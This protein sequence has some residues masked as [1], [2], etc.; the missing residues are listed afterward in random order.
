MHG[1]IFLIIDQHLAA[2]TE[3]IQQTTK[4][5]RD[6][7]VFSKIL[8]VQN[9]VIRSKLERYFWR[10]QKNIGLTAL[11]RSVKLRSRKVILQVQHD[12]G[13]PLAPSTA[14][15]VHSV[16]S[17]SSESERSTTSPGNSKSVK[18]EST[19]DSLKVNITKFKY[20]YSTAEEICSQF[21]KER[22]QKVETSQ[23]GS[24]PT[25]YKKKTVSCIYYYP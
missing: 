2:P 7:Y 13:Q 21:Q 23:E 10:L 14:P 9:H 17:I 20:R 8:K 3:N 22:R 12:L 19:V 15:S 5:D 24:R 25:P 16:I 1:P 18:S 4:P 6:I 11:D